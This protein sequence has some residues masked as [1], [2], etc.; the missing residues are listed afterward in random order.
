M[1]AFLFNETKD[2]RG[3]EAMNH[4][5]LAAK[6]GEEMR[7][8]PAIRVEKRNGVQFDGAAFDVE[9]QANVH[10]VKIYISVREHYT[11]GIRAGSAGIEK[12]GKGVF[13]DSG[14]IGAIWLSFAKKV[15]ITT[16]RQPGCFWRAFE[17]ADH[18][19]RRNDV[20][21]RLHQS[22]QLL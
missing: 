5:M 8:T 4:H 10:R 12:L 20:A 9:S 19:Y 21:R 11:F 3:F 18:F 13:I 16:R 1:N 17:Q 7:D 14:D 15:L 2:F 22:E 6:K